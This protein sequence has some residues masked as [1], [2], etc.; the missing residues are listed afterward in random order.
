M[1]VTLKNSLPKDPGAILGLFT[2]NQNLGD[3]GAQ[4]Q[5]FGEAISAMSKAVSGENKIDE[6]AVNN[7]KNAGIMLTELQNAIPDSR[8]F[9]GKVSL[10]DFGS[11]IQSFGYGLKTY[12]D[13]LADIYVS[14]NKSYF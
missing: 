12:S 14:K 6:D 4:A 2:S 7:A 10:S 8:W 11:N 5:Q 13:Y 1:L 9:D 3:F